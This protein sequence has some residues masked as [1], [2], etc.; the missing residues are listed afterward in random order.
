MNI[1]LLGPASLISEILTASLFAKGHTCFLVD[2]I[3]SASVFIE[4]IP[5]FDII[6]VDS[7]VL[8]SSLVDNVVRTC[9]FYSKPVVLITDKFVTNSDVFQVVSREELFT[10]SYM[11]NFIYEI[12][13]NVY[14]GNLDVRSS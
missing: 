10:Y 3:T 14:G 5:I 9:S 8:D 13:K 2:N 12:E 11:E 1:L 7:Y 6:F 4:S